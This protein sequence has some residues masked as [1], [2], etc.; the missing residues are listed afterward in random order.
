MIC[1]QYRPIL[2]LVVRLDLEILEDI[3]GHFYTETKVNFVHIRN[4]RRV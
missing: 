2:H 1:V 3:M 4:Y